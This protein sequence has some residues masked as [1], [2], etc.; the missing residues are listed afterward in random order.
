VLDERTG[1]YLTLGRE[2]GLLDDRV[3]GLAVNREHLWV[4][5][6]GGVSRFRLAALFP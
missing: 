6:P 1:G 5:T 3:L 4:S 2:S